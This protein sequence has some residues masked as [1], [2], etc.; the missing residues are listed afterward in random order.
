MASQSGVE[1]LKD[2]LH[3]PSHHHSLLLL[4]IYTAWGCN[5][6]K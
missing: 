3:S 5:N 4:P 6:A 2:V 1:D